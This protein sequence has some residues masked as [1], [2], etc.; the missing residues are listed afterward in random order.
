[1]FDVY[2]PAV[3]VT[4]GTLVRADQRRPPEPPEALLTM[5]ACLRRDDEGNASYKRPVHYCPGSL[6]AR[7]PTHTVPYASFTIGAG[8]GKYKKYDKYHS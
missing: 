5:P 3:Q 7:T 8:S 4:I 6:R 1:M 2:C